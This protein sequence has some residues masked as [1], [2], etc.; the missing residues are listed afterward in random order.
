VHTIVK[1]NAEHV[2]M[3]SALAK[4]TFLESHG[5]SAG[6]DDIDAYIDANLNYS[7]LEKELNDP[8]NIYHLLFQDAIAAGYSKIKLN[9]PYPGSERS[10]I[11][12][13]ERIYFRKEFYGLDLGQ[14]LFEFNL[15]LAKENQQ[16][17]I[18]LFVWKENHRAVSFYKKNGFLIVGSYDF[19]IS[20]KHSNPNHIMF[21]SL[22]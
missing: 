13:L 20:D 2:D 19:K 5:H 10:N 15:R 1:A 9:T 22:E 7:A 11:T 16:A 12:K 4:T 14:A 17:G 8:N 21:L 3:L 18:W 6:P